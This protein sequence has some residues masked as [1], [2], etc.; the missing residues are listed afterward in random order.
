MHLINSWP[1][2]KLE[3]HRG[4]T[5]GVYDSVVMYLYM[6]VAGIAVA[7]LVALLVLAVCPLLSVNSLVPAGLTPL[8]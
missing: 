6:I 5:Q 1:S 3:F 4:L 8:L 7:V 2:I